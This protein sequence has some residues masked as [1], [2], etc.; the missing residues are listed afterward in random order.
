VGA[1]VLLLLG[2]ALVAWF[3]AGPSLLALRRARIARR[4]FPPA[5]RAVL[6]RW[7][8]YRRLPA[9]LQLQL[10][11]QIQVFLHDKRIVGCAGLEVTDEMRVLVAAQ[12]CLLLLNRRGARYA[13]LTEVLLYPGA[14]IVEREHGDGSGVRQRRRDVLTGE[15]WVQGQVVLSWDD[16]LAGALD[17]DDG[18][19]V[20]IHE[21]AH[22]LDQDKGHANGAP[23]AGRWA[24][25]R[26]QRWA[27]VFDEAFTRLRA[28]AA[29]YAARHAAPQPSHGAMPAD[30]DA[31][32]L[33]DFYG[34][35]DPAEFFAVVSEVFFERPQPLAQQEPA[36]YRELA[37]FFRVDPLAW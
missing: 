17:A 35:T 10:K 20:V 11:R 1:I 37:A 12:A 24:R 14:F 7:P 30:A 25:A 32:P 6:R 36:L 22:Q 3:A 28:Q 5:W 15:S 9:D 27:Q 4:P 21:F 8:L 19:N 26:M 31:P 18:R 16:A 29:Q 13:R 33:I 34:A 23:A 2:L